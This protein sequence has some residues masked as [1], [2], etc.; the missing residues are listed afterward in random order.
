MWRPFLVVILVITSFVTQAQQ[1]LYPVH[2]DKKWGMMDINGNLVVEPSYHAIGAFQEGLYAIAEKEGLLGVLDTTGTLVIPCTYTLMDYVGRGL[3]SV[4]T[5]TTS[6]SIIN[7]DEQLILD[8]MAA[9][10]EFLQGPFLSYEEITGKGLAHLEKGVILPPE[11][12][13]FKFLGNG[14]IVASDKEDLKSIYDYDGNQ[15]LTRGYEK[16]ELKNNLIWARR[17]GK[18]GAFTLKGT[19]VIKHEWI[20]YKAVGENF[21]HF[22]DEEKKSFLY[23]VELNTVILKNVWNM[24]LLG[25]THVEALMPSGTRNLID[26][27]GR[28]VLS[29]KYDFITTFGEDGFKV[30]EGKI[31][32]VFDG[33]GKVLI[34]MTY[35][36]IGG[37]NSTVALV[38][39]GR[40]HGVINF[41]GEVVLPISFPHAL[42]LNENKASYR[43]TSGSLQL[44]AFDANGQ[45]SENIKYSNLKSLKV[46]SSGYGR[47]SNN[48]A[49]GAIAVAPDSNPFQISDS[50]CWLFHVGAEKWGLWHMQE[51]R[52]KFPP[53]WD[54]VQVLKDQNISIVN[55]KKQN[56]GGVINTGRIRLKSHEVFG[57]FTNVHGLPITRMEFLDI[58][59][60]DFT[61]EKLE[62]ARC[63]FVGGKHGIIASNG[64][65]ITRGF[66]Y[67]GE[68]VEGKARATRKGYLLVDLEGKVK[69]PIGKSF[70]F[71]D[72]LMANCRFDNDDDPKFYRIFET[73][74]ELYCKDA[75]WGYLDTFGAVNSAFKYD[76]AEDYSNDRALVRKDGKWGMLDNE[77]TEVLKP[78]YD[79]FNFLPNANQ[80]LFFIAKNIV[81]HGAIDSNANVIVPVKY[82]KVRAYQEDRVAVKNLG[83]RWGFVNRTGKEVVKTQYRVARDFSEGLSIIFDQSRWGAINPSGGI[84]IKPQYLKMGDFKEGKAWVHLPKGKKGYITK[85]GELLF[86]RRFSK[87]TSFK[88]GIARVYIRKK[89]W[90]LINTKGEFI[91]KP[92]KKYEK[93]EEF[94]EHGLAKVKIGKK[95]RL[96]NELG[97]LVGK[98][99]YGTIREFKEGFAAV[100]IQ[101][102]TGNHIGKTNLNWMFIDTTGE[103]VI[104][105]E[106][107]QLKNFSEGRAAFT[108]E[109]SKRGYINTKGEV[110]I[111]PIYFRVEPF[112]NNRALVWDSYNRTGVIDTTGKVI[113][114]VEYNRILD[115]HKGLALVRKN[116]WTYYFVHEDTKRHTPNNFTGAKGFGNDAAPIRIKD[117]WGVINEQGLQLLIPKY[118]KIEPFKDGVANVSITNLLGVVDLEGRVI[119]EPEYE[120]VDYVG[121]GLFRVEQGDQMG[122]LNMSGDWVWKLR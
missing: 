65:I 25:K 91:L 54:E 32:G 108:S 52:F 103:V 23:S 99:A 121:N 93:I 24:R 15:I 60:S 111:D 95:Y 44:F 101:A 61:V 17:S 6:W 63:V 39:R 13:E 20:S 76:Y 31:Q 18:W 1:H 86:A 12:S 8:D 102:L 114:P 122:Y 19:N 35:N 82:S 62:V 84:A 50:L 106:F 69:R 88:N 10:I 90:G 64:K 67:I 55:R 71:F 30:K 40:K 3:F 33:E 4:K 96:M 46:R 87:L 115:I 107:R 21:Y 38:R 77:G 116:S 28:I 56:I 41:K 118:A 27:A 78:A 83:G 48:M 68:F 53:Q 43:D 105:E 36:H 26:L 104:N 9:S 14:L 29:G 92:Q 51:E 57:V 37:L 75:E 70:T 119:I 94:N 85:S 98:K 45:L 7:T 109:E 42:E 89:G 11:F 47:R 81:L 80:K 100:R 110:I 49:G 72:R 16:I 73:T 58:R 97:E 112:E 59:I 22:K 74:G 5:P 34:P 113:I 66:A 117:K 79:N 120:Y 2:I